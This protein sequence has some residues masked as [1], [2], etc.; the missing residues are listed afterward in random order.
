[1][2]KTS[3]RK[4]SN[5]E[6]KRL[7]PRHIKAIHLHLQGSRLK[8]IAERTNL[9]PWWIS[10]ILKS[11]LARKAVA[12]YQESMD[13]EFMA[14]YGR[15]VEAVK[16]GLSDPDVTVR[17]QAVDRWLKTQ[18]KRLGRR[19]ARTETAEDVV[20]RLMELRLPE[21]PQKEQETA[22]TGG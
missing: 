5:G 8:Q 16:S 11:E 7:T 6:L 18:E 21:S 4:A 15:A 19:E 20:K 14:Q 1:M 12:E 10:R 22:R 17:L 2:S 13:V 3:S 9:S